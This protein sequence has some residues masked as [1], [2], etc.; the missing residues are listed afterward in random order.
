[1]QQ[2]GLIPGRDAYS[3]T[4]IVLDMYSL[5][6]YSRCFALVTDRLVY[7]STLDIYWPTAIFISIIFIMQTPD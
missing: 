7:N 5:L 4:K 6:G 2:L 1:M 3:G